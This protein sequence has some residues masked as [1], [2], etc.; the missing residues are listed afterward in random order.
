M[1]QT[2]GSLLNPS[3][4]DVPPSMHGGSWGSTLPSHSLCPP[5]VPHGLTGHPQ[6]VPE[7]GVP[8]GVGG[9]AAVAAG[10]RK[11][12]TGDLQALPIPGQDP[13]RGG[14][15]LLVPLVPGDV[16]REGGG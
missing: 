11:V 9:H 6:A 3:L 8:G 7:L 5:P 2:K 13:A 12:G 1:G 10:I 14:H 16:C 4:R 15:K